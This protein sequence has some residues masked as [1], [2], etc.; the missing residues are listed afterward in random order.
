[1]PRTTTAPLPAQTTRVTD[2]PKA[3]SG[4]VVVGLLGFLFS[5]HE[6]TVSTL[7]GVYTC[8]YLDIGALGVAALVAILTLVGLIRRASDPW[9]NRARWWLVWAVAGLNAVLVVI[10]VLRGVGVIGGLC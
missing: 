3:L 2:L 5:F 6:Y 10:H 4:A 1:M 8:F 7:S 9:T